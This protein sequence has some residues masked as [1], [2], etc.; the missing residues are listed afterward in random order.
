MTLDHIKQCTHLYNRHMSCI[1]RDFICRQSEPTEAVA[2]DWRPTEVQVFVGIGEF[3]ELFDGQIHSYKIMP[4]LWS[5]GRELLLEM[6]RD[7]V[8]PHVYHQYREIRWVRGDDYKI[9]CKN[10][11]IGWMRVTQVVCP[12]N[13]LMPAALAA[14]LPAPVPQRLR[15]RRQGPTGSY[16]QPHVQEQPA[17]PLVNINDMKNIDYTVKGS[18]QGPS[19]PRG[20]SRRQMRR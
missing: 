13:Q 19:N 4:D 14:P 16:R 18:P 17:I 10:T 9:W 1:S 7:W 20:G 12:M 3:I 11:P 2:S 6:S 8:I 5:G 15:P